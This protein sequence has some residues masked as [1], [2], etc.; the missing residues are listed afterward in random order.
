MSSYFVDVDLLTAT[1]SVSIPFYFVSLPAG[2]KISAEFVYNYY[3]RDEGISEVTALSATDADSD[4]YDFILENYEKGVYPRQINLAF[5]SRSSVT[6]ETLDPGTIERAVKEGKIIYEDSPFGNGYSAVIVHDTS[7]DEKIYATDL[8]ITAS[9]G[10]STRS[11]DFLNNARLQSEGYRFSKAQAREEI[12]AEYE[13]DVKSFNLEISLNNLVVHDV[14]NTV[15]KW[16]SSAYADE[17]AKAAEDAKSTQDEQRATSADS[18]FSI[19]QSEVDVSLGAISKKTVSSIPLDSFYSSH[20]TTKVGYIIEKYGEQLDQSTLRYDDFFIENSEISSLTDTTVRYGGVYKYKI[21]TVYKTTIIASSADLS[22]D[23]E[24][25]QVL[26]ASTGKYTTVL[27]TEN[28]PPAPPNNLS[29]F[30]TLQ[31]LNISW[32][33]PMNTQK[34]IKRFQVFRRPTIEDPFELIREINFDKTILPY[35]T[36]ERVPDAVTQKTDGPV[37][38]FVDTDFVLLESDYIYAICAIDAHG[39]SSAYSEQFRVRFDNITGKMIITR[40]STEG[41]PKPYPNVNILGD[42]FSDLIKDSEN[43]RIRVYFDPEYLDVKRSGSSLSLI[44]TEGY[45]GVNYKLSLTEINLGKNQTVDIAI[46]DGTIGSDGIPLSIA[47]YY[48]PS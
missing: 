27:C 30:Q 46:G 36:G 9:S 40:V 32:N 24:I 31:G 12:V 38:S 10:L 28:I 8:D 1:S 14:L 7:V 47:R 17:F 26:F 43:S 21:R 48:K 37:K 25:S 2:E 22:G 19:L 42:F 44:S 4:S 45:N 33:F 20:P 41:A 13:S 23:F 5:S 34:D 18:A 3:T 16:Q 6:S 35:S 11:S 15:Q 39:Y 29:F